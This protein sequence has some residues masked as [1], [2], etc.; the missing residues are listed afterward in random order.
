[1]PTQAKIEKVAELQQKLENC[2][3]AVT[4]TYTNIT[5]NEMTDL[6]RRTR[7]AGFEFLVIKNSLLSLAADAA[8]LPQLKD[9][10][11]GPTAVAFG[12]DEPVDVAKTL[13]DYIRNNRSALSIQGAIVS[14]GPA[15]LTTEVERLA[16]LPPRPQLL[17]MLLG[18]IQSP[19]SGLI[20]ILNGPLW[21]FGGIL[22]ARIQ[23]LESGA[24]AEIST[25]QAE[26]GAE[27]ESG[28]SEAEAGPETVAETEAEPEAVESQPEPEATTETEAEP[29]AVES[30]PEPEATTETDAEPEAVESQPEPEAATE[31]AAEP[32]SVESQPDAEPESEA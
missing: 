26:S 21:S 9:I 25:S 6:R 12:Y 28:D 32:E 3:I 11:Q 29:E 17:A 10:M 24:E 22:Q 30:Q 31:T 20:N 8:Q 18:Q 16:S 2:S 15:L 1:M 5:V 19:I 7:E 23:Q 27:A 14:G 13:N 4:A